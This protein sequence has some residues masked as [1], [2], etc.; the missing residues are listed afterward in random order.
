MVLPRAAI[1]KRLYGQSSSVL[2]TAELAIVRKTLR[3]L[4]HEH[5]CDLLVAPVKATTTRNGLQ[6]A[7]CVQSQGECCGGATLRE[8]ATSA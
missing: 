2:H 5:Q 7:I 8:D 1:L 4:L 3:P 6:H